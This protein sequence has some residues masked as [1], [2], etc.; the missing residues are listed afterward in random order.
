MH[1]SHPTRVLVSICRSI[2]PTAVALGALLFA[3]ACN[4]DDRLHT[5]P[6]GAGSNGVGTAGSNSAGSAGSNNAGSA[7]SNSAGSAASNSPGSAGSAGSADSNSAG[8]AGSDSAGS[9]GSDSA[10]SA[11]SDSAGG[12][13]TAGQAGSG[14]TAGGNA[15]AGAGGGSGQTTNCVAGGTPFVVGNYVDA[16]GRQL[17]LRTAAKAAT[18][19]L[20]PAG[21]ANSALPP[22]LFLVE[23]VCASGG[24]LIAKDESSAYRV[25]FLQSGSQFAIC[26]SAAVATLD[27]ALV[28]APANLAHAAD[29]GCA[30]KPFTVYTAEAL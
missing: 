17:L 13:D 7:G 30:G 10:G 27:A 29:T 5:S 1:L 4:D 22:Q 15:G 26:L 16:S 19:A 14:G 20:V 25:D 21:A 2:S 9:A 8:S 23:R 6:G 12:A 11:G 18:F 24:A 3:V 28:L